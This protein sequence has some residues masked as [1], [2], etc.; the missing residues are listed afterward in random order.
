MIVYL[1]LLC[2]HIIGCVCI[3]SCIGLQPYQYFEFD[4]YGTVTS[5]QTNVNQ[6]IVPVEL[7]ALPWNC[8]NPT[9]LYSRDLPN[10]VSIGFP[11][12]KFGFPV[13]ILSGKVTEPCS[14]VSFVK[15]VCGVTTLDYV[16]ISFEVI[17]K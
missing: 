12:D 6:T 8:M 14:F 16:S 7:P 5:I 9:F 4:K 2:F 1:I 15:V 17:Q 11:K 13:P 10:G 3:L